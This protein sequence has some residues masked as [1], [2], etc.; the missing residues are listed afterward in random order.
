MKDTE[1]FGNI[2]V[3][4]LFLVYLVVVGILCLFDIE[5]FCLR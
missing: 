4:F 5:I 3:L 2:S 1:S